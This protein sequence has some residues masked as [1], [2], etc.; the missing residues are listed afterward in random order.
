[1]E[2]ARKIVELWTE[3]QTRQLTYENA[4]AQNKQL[5]GSV[6]APELIA[7]GAS[8]T[9]AEM[10]LRCLIGQASS[11]AAWGNSAAPFER[12]VKPLQLPRGVI[13][14]RFAMR[15]SLRQSSCLLRR[16]CKM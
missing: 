13:V 8:V 14:Q 15:F 11:S 4:L 9:Q 1:M 3:R 5:P 10:E 7:S 12:P 16:R 2:V 6:S